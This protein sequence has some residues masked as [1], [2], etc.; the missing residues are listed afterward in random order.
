[1]ELETGE[2]K[3]YDN[4]RINCH[5]DFDVLEYAAKV[6]DQDRKWL[7]VKHVH[8]KKQTDHWHVCGVMKP[9]VTHLQEH[10]LRQGAGKGGK[11]I[12]KK[13][14]V[15]DEGTFNYCLK[16]AEWAEDGCVV[17]TNMTDDEIEQRAIDSAAYHEASKDV[18][19][20]ICKNTKSN[21]TE[22]PK[23]FHHR[24]MVLC[25][26]ELRKNKVQLGPWLTHKV[27]S[28]LFDRE[29]MQ[30]YITNRYL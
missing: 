28:L 17:G 6:L 18:V 26:K 15:Y 3:I 4:I 24:V 14:Q 1:M 20:E 10:P 27:R 25:A 8:G 16:P 11:P 5:A 22:E 21:L 13:N 2:P 9:G 30:D 12:Q 23:E 7:V 19:T 29:F